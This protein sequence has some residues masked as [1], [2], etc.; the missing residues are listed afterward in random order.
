MY[1]IYKTTFK[2]KHD[3]N[4]LHCNNFN[5]NI[6]YVNI[7]NIIKKLFLNNFIMFKYQT[8]LIN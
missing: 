2:M 3:N 1:F 7:Y 6:T 4:L 8:L 5:N